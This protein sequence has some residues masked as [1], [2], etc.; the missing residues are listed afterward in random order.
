LGGFDLEF[1]ALECQIVWLENVF[2]ECRIVDAAAN[3]CIV[4]NSVC[5]WDAWSYLKPL[6]ND[7]WIITTATVTVATQDVSVGV[8]RVN[9]EAAGW[10]QDD[11][12][13]KTFLSKN[14]QWW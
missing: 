11:A 14:Q 6:L 7:F 3:S 4:D 5:Y 13:T 10:F 12:C 8:D 2:L 1:G 9:F